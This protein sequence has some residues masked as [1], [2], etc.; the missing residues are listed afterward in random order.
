MSEHVYLSVG[1]NLGDRLGQLR[2]VVRALRELTG[3]RFVGASRVY[4]TEPWDTEPG[5]LPHEQPWFLNCVVEIDTDLPATSLLAQLQRIES[6]LGRTRPEGTPEHGRFVPRTVDIDILFYGARVIS[7]PDQ[8]HV[9]HLLAH[10]RAFVLRPLADLAPAL[11]HPTLY[12]TVSELLDE[13]SDEHEI[14]PGAAGAR[15][16]D[17]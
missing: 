1:S 5:Q 4:E 8:L 6:G 7:V 2:A 9:P 12:R 3:V 15:W 11:E 17:D 16:F 13:L 10:E 14:R